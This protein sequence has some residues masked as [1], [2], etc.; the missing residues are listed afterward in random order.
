L[1]K[2]F[3]LFRFLNSNDNGK[4]SAEMVRK[5]IFLWLGRFP[6]FLSGR[7]KLGSKALT[8]HRNGRQKLGIPKQG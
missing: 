5:L 1:E 8:N 7:K 3:R 6:L 4:G 2:P